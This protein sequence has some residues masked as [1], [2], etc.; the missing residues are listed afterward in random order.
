[1]SYETWI[2]EGRGV[3]L[4]DV[5]TS[6]ERVEKL[7]EMEP[8]IRETVH[9]QIREQIGDPKAPTSLEDYEAYEFEEAGYSTGIGAILVAIIKK[10]EGYELSVVDDFDGNQFLIF[11]KTYPWLMTSRCET[12]LTKGGLDEA[13]SRYI[14]ILT[15]KEIEVEYQ[16]AENGG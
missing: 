5:E 15:D 13:I 11:E 1:M 3:R 14:K 4:T 7:L 2:I 8:E 12:G 16:R 9:A 10:R 6:V